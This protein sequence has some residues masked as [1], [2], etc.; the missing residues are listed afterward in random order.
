MCGPNYP[1]FLIVL[2]DHFSAPNNLYYHHA[3]ILVKFNFP[4]SLKLLF[5]YFSVLSAVLLQ[6]VICIQQEE[7][8]KI[9]RVHNSFRRNY[10]KRGLQN[11]IAN[12]KILVSS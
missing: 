9:L 4:S 10:A 1:V 7:I 6:N 3:L 2:I 5:L 11:E 8:Q 12:M